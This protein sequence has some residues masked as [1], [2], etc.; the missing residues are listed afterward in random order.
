MLEVENSV[1][2]R[3][4]N[5]ITFQRLQACSTL[6]IDIAFGIARLTKEL[7]DKGETYFEIKNQLIQRYC[8]KDENGQP[9]VQED[10]QLKIQ[11]YREEFME[12]MQKLLEQ[13]VQL[14]CSKVVIYLDEL[15]EHQEEYPVHERLKMS[16]LQMMELD[17]SDVLEMKAHE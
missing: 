4:S 11:E 12:E 8:D 16:P 10:G 17:V 15:Q 7:V 14:N 3:F 6:P 13:K 5:N 2:E 9:I 1:F